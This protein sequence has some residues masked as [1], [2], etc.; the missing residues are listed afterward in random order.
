MN[1]SNRYRIITGP[2]AED[3]FMA[4][5]MNT[6]HLDAPRLKLSLQEITG[7]EAPTE[8]IDAKA[9]DL[10]V[11]RL[12]HAI[13]TP[14]TPQENRNDWAIY[15]QGKFHEDEEDFIGTNAKITLRYNP[16]TRDGIAEVLIQ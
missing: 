4:F 11:F 9:S 14:Q 13:C 2:S 10:H 5:G 16:H 6:D 3:I 7:N 1:E 12:E 15:C 8:Q